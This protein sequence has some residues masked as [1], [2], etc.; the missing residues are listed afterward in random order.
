M[1]TGSNDFFGSTT[2]LKSVVM[3]K[4]M[5]KSVEKMQPNYKISYIFIDKK[6]IESIVIHF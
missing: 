6:I 3:V 1:L 5:Y 2:V 4:H